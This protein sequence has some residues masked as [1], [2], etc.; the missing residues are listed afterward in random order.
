MVAGEIKAQGKPEQV[1]LPDLI[2]DAYCLPVQVVKPPFLDIPPGITRY[3]VI[4]K[5][6][7]RRFAWRLLHSQPLPP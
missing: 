7:A 3:K 1:L 6:N 2:R 5:I 4:L